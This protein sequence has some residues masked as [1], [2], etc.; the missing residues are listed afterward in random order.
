MKI[1]RQ[2]NTAL[3]EGLAKS[4]F[5][6][7]RNFLMCAFL[8][9]IGTAEFKQHTSHFLGLVSSSYSGIGVIGL[10][11]ILICLNLYDGIRK[12][13]RTRYHLILTIILISIYIFLSIRV[14][15]MTWNFRTTP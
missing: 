5:D 14:V 4:V 9:S 10:S 3:D 2:I 8:L 13:S 6:H 12:I 15:E 1:I 11:I 7:I